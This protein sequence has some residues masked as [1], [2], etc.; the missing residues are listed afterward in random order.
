MQTELIPMIC[1]LF[2]VYGG[3]TNLK[4]V[5]KSISPLHDAGPQKCLTFSVD[6]SRFASG[7][8]VRNAV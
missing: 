4:L 7:G 3:E 2:E 1:R 5:A 8:V 6:G